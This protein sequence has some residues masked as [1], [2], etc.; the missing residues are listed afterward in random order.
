[1]FQRVLELKPTAAHKFFRRSDRNFI[2]CTDRITGFLSNLAI[3]PDLARQ[4]RTF[5]LLPTSTQTAL[6][7]RLIQSLHASAK[8][9][10]SVPACL[11]SL[12]SVVTGVRP[13][14]SA[15]Q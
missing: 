3:D 4:N 13:V 15:G 8:S 5:S 12:Q 7:Q 10:T 14:L 6:D 2:L 9:S 11:V 1:M